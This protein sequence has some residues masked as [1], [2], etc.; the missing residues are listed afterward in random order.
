MGKFNAYS[1]LDLEKMVQYF[2]KIDF[3]FDTEVKI[4]RQ[5][6]LTKITPFRNKGGF[7]LEE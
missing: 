3:Q 7:N 5:N 2:F 1:K 4:W 6:L